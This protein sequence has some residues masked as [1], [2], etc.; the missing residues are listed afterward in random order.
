MRV[1]RLAPRAVA[2]PLL[3]AALIAGMP[4]LA[5]KPAAAAEPSPEGAAS[6]IRDLAHRAIVNLGD[7]GTSYET[8]AKQF[9]ELLREGFAI[10]AISR[11]VLGRYWRVATEAEQQAFRDTFERVIAQRFLP[12]FE[13]YTQDDFVVE[14]ARTDPRNPALYLVDTRIAQPGEREGMV[15]AGWRI[16]HEG[17]AYAIVDV[18]AEGVSMAITLRSEYTSVVQRNGGRIQALIDLLERKLAAGAFRPDTAEG[19]VQ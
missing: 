16:R 10:D 8:R 3:A 17:D 13:R 14:G 15:Q 2:A 11:F 12:L 4:A 9:R 19:M 1:P 18:V 7:S 5:G 6:F